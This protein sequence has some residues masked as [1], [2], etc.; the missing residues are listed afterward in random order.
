MLLG[1]PATRSFLVPLLAVP[2]EGV[3]SVTE[4]FFVLSGASDVIV[5]S[6]LGSFW[7]A[8]SSARARTIFVAR[9]ATD[10]RRMSFL[11]IGQFKKRKSYWS[12]F[13]EQDNPG[14]ILKGHNAGREDTFAAFGCDPRMYEATSAVAAC[15]LFRVQARVARMAFGS[16]PRAGRLWVMPCCSARFLD[17]SVFPSPSASGTTI[18]SLANRALCAPRMADQW[19][20]TAGVDRTAAYAQRSNDR[21]GR[22]S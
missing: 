18:P 17:I 12:E 11:L 20:A 2:G 15:R 8:L 3:E 22:S 16:R 7:W 9:Y 1:S 5:F 10:S 6:L 4:P 21:R 19:F 14:F 13:S